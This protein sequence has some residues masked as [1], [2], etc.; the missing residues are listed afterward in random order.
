MPA[1]ADGATLATVLFAGSTGLATFFAP[2]AFPLLPGYVGFYLS[3]DD[4][5]T[6]TDAVPAAAVA[7]AGAVLALG[8]LLA[9]AASAGRRFLSALVWFE[10]VVGVALLLV[11][12]AVAT[13]RAPSAHVSLP[14]RPRSLA[15]FGVFGAA[16]AVAAAGCLVPLVTGVVAQAATLPA[17]GTAAALA[18]YVAGVATPLIGVTLLS[19]AG[20]ERWRAGGRHLGRVRVLAGAAMVLA[21]LGQLALAADLLAT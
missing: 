11:G 10:P 6:V 20:V 3:H 4:R 13:D 21:G 5:T 1:P 16:Y 17:A 15:G 14:R 18:A 7:A 9:V 8:G 19:A 2:C 12:L